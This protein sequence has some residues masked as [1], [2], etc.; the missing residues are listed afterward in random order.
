[1]LPGCACPQIR[2]GGPGRLSLSRAFNVAR[3][4]GCPR[5][6]R[7][8]AGQRAFKPEGNKFGFKT[9]REDVVWGGSSPSPQIQPALNK[10][11][12]VSSEP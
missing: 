11:G 4:S 7:Y 10:V 6:R 9:S 3:H 1:M 12:L 5:E 2:G 8:H